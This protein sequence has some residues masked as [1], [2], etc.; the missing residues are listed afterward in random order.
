MFSNEII[1]R[2]SGHFSRHNGRIG[3]S[4]NPNAVIEG[5]SDSTKFNMFYAVTT[6]RNIWSPS[7]AESTVSGIV[8]RISDA[9]FGRRGSS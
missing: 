6:R 4:N 3:G 2:L 8:G 7:F 9:G 1:L 5:I